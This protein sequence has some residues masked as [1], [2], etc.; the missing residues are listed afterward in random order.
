MVPTLIVYACVL[1][2]VYAFI[3]NVSINA[4]GIAA[5]CLSAMAVLLQGASDIQMHRFRK[6]KTG[7]FIREGFWKHSR[8]PNY[9][10]E[11]LMWWGIAIS[12]WSADVNSFSLLLGAFANTLLFLFI[13]IP[14]ADK[15]QSR[16]D[17]FSEYKSETRMLL[18]IKK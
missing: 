18:P 15:H 7:G 11:I 14:M 1:P 17:G 5:I 12:V 10:G 13:S 3:N 6:N 8:H 9:L 2:A 16:K 4:F